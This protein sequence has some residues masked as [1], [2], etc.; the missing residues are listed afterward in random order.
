MDDAQEYAMGNV[1]EARG[2]NYYIDPKFPL[3]LS[4]VH[5]E[6]RLQHPYDLTCEAHYHNFSE[7]V[8][9]IAGSG[10]QE[11]D[12]ELFPVAAG[13]VFMLQPG[14]VHHFLERGTMEIY[15]VQFEPE[16]LP[17]PLDMLRQLP[18][19]NMIFQVEPVFRSPRRAGRR[20]SLGEDELLGVVR[21][22][23]RIDIELRS[24]SISGQCAALAVLFEL[25]VQLSRRRDEQSRSEVCAGLLPNI[26]L[27]IGRLE[28]GYER[29]W[30]LGE[31]AKLACTSV[32]HFLR[33]FRR[34]TGS[35]P[36]NYLLALR[37]RRAAEMLSTENDPVAV[38]A[39]K[40]GFA[41]SNYFSR[42]FS[43]HFG[44]SPRDF[45]R[46]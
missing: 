46:R 22:L 25:L 36:H 42:C 19:Y 9:V 40:C 32:N 41:D 31:M 14:S 10:T 45:R 1:I 34:A 3:A 4:I 37:L 26:A 33:L 23:T 7:L 13:D 30:T 35:T 38:V 8:I 43:R 12:G 11:V 21:M 18:G 27:V 2:E 16:K 17:L 6:N 28:N 24:R 44:C 20:L 29:P 39:E 15:N 5:A